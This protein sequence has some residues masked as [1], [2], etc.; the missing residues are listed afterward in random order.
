M[1]HFAI[2]NLSVAAAK[3]WYLGFVV[4]DKYLYR[5]HDLDDGFMTPYYRIANVE[6]EM[7]VPRSF[8]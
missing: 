5:N 1:G 6:R 2:P 7:F 3:C 4:P 8:L